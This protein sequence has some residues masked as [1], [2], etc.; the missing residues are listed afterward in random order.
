MVDVTGNS[1]S[2]DSDNEIDFIYIDSLR[3]TY[4]EVISN[5]GIIDT[6]CRTRTKLY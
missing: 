3:L 1:M 4:Q 5:N 6:H 2:E